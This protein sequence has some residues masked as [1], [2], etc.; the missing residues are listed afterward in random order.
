MTVR[1]AH[2]RLAEH[3]RTNLPHHIPNWHAADHVDFDDRAQHLDDLLAAV[4]I[5]ALSVMQ[6]TKSHANIRVDIPNIIGAFEDLRGDT[7]GQ[8]RNCA[9]DLRNGMGRAA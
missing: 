3:L 1:A 6:D 7:A 9:D 4:G 8:L 2:A 5:Y